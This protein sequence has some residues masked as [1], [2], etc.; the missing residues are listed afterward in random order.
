MRDLDCNVDETKVISKFNEELNV[1]EFQQRIEY[2][3]KNTCQVCF[4]GSHGR[5]VLEK[6]VKERKSIIA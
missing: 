1:I 6:I 2:K 4:F 5:K 3:R